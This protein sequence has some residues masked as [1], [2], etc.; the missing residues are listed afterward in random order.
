MGDS[1]SYF[2]GYVLAL[3][4]LA[5]VMQKASTTI[6]LLVPILALGVPILDTLF[7]IVRRSIERRPIFSPDRGHIHHRL[8]DLGLTHRRAVLILYGM[9][10]ILTAGAIVA[11]I[12]CPIP[13]RVPAP[14]RAAFLPHP[15]PVPHPVP[16]LSRAPSLPRPAPCPHPVRVAFLP[17][18][19]RRSCRRPPAPPRPVPRQVPTLSHAPSLPCPL[20]RPCPVLHPVPAPSCA[21][22]LPCWVPVPCPPVSC[23]HARPTLR[24]ASPPAHPC[25]V[26][27]HIPTLSCAAFAA[28]SLPCPAPCPRP[29]PCTVPTPR[30]VPR[31]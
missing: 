19:V 12:G 26:L 1:G 6:A 23:S 17:R 13:C 30:P 7:S 15:R 28:P 31:P 5:G 22:S 8:L 25:P 2:L 29:V 11:S 21:P 24:A 18:P 9:C 14:S 3:S 16:T 20:P 10:A 4:S 27:C